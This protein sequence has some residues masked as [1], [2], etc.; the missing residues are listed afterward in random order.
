M[1]PVRI[2]NLSW[3]HTVD[4]GG[5]EEDYSVAPPILL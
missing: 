4:G 3:Y 1:S 5:R 2:I